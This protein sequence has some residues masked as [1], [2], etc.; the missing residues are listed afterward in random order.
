MNKKTICIKTGTK[1]EVEEK[2]KEILEDYRE[3]G[4]IVVYD[5]VCFGN[6]DIRYTISNSDIDFALIQEVRRNF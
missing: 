3:K 1:A 2:Q 5:S 4:F 6:I